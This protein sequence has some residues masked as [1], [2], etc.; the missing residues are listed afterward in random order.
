M[1]RGVAGRCNEELQGKLRVDA[2]RRA[3]LLRV[4]AT[5]FRSSLVEG[6]LPTEP[7]YT[8]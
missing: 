7:R 3:S 5:S 4:G 1:Q 6:L 2:T 8:V